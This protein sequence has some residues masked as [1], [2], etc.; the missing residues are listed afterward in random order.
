[1]SDRINHGPHRPVLRIVENEQILSY[2]TRAERDARATELAQ[3][4]TVEIGMLWMESLGYV[5]DGTT[6]FHFYTDSMCDSLIRAKV[7]VS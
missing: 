6:R 3:H 5:S 4:F 7:L 1:M 2:R